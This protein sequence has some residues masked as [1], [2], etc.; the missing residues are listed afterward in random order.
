MS[1]Y[2][3]STLGPFRWEMLKT[4]EKEILKI[5]GTI[6]GGFVSDSII[7][8]HYAELYYKAKNDYYEE[9]IDESL[10]QA[11]MQEEDSTLTEYANQENE[12][13]SNAIPE[14]QEQKE[15]MVW[16]YTNSK[17]HPE[18]WPH[19]TRQPED[20]D[21]VIHPARLQQFMA[22]L[23]E[24]GLEYMQLFRHN[25]RF[26]LPVEDRHNIEHVRFSV[27]IAVPWKFAKYM[28]L[29]K[30]HL[31]VILDPDYMIGKT[32]VPYGEPDFECNR[33]ILTKHG[34]EFHGIAHPMR[35]LET[36]QK[37]IKDILLFQAVPIRAPKYRMVRM[38]NKGYKIVSSNYTVIKNKDSITPVEGC[39]LHCLEGFEPTDFSVKNKCCQ[40]RYH[41]NCYME[42]QK[43]CTVQY[44][45]V[46]FCALCRTKMD[47]EE[48]EV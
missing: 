4:I 32:A 17:S 11:F 37:I 36:L 26:Y 21:F 14:K 19:R 7:H 8:N 27:T 3:D 25:V 47:R 48:R 43:Q 6:F 23:R 24:A 9:S 2:T 29:P 46:D 40:A 10:D 34:Y 30:V 44:N 39:C 33:I 15:P 28:T 18:S 42:T 13:S 16:S 38:L 35:K 12:P 22:N 45:N 41:I 5:D 31:D 1:N 20:I